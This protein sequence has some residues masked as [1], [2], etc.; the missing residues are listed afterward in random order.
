MQELSNCNR[1]WTVPFSLFD[2]LIHCNITC[3]T[4]SS[5]KEVIVKVQKGRINI[6]EEQSNEAIHRNIMAMSRILTFTL[7]YSDQFNFDNYRPHKSGDLHFPT[8]RTWE[9]VQTFSIAAL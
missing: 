7:M 2:E 3:S 8:S 5:S 6:I 1:V 4:T 9:R